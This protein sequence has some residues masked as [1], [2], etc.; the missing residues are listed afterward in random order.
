MILDFI[1]GVARPVVLLLVNGAT[2]GMIFYQ[3]AVPQEWWVLTGGVNAW[4][5]WS[6]TQEHQKNGG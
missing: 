5:F 3:I 6:R 1:R 4:W 2:V